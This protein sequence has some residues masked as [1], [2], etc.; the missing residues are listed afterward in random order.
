[1]HYKLRVWG[2]LLRRVLWVDTVE[3][4]WVTI[5]AHYGQQQRERA[6]ALARTALAELAGGADALG[7]PAQACPLG[8]VIL[9]TKLLWCLPWVVA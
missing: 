8:L 3:L 7:A 6:A 9:A 1:M 4:V 5:L 2:V